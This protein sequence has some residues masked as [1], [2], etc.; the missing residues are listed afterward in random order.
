MSKLT[1]PA[2]IGN[3]LFGVGVDYETVIKCAQRH[4]EY[5]SVNN[6]RKLNS[7]KPS[8]QWIDNIPD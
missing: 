2:K 1:K 7:H 4:Y 5:D 6:E 3:T 8:T